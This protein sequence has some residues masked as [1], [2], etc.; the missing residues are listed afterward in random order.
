MATFKNRAN[1]GKKV[2]ELN[3][4]LDVKQKRFLSNWKR[5]SFYVEHEMNERTRAKSLESSKLQL[6]RTD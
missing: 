2:Q 3:S 4:G 1:D 6:V 5:T